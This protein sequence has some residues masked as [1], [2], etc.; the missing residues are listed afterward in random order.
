VREGF[1]LDLRLNLEGRR[2][3]FRRETDSAFIT[4]DRT[5]APALSAQGYRQ[6]DARRLIRAARAGPHGRI[7][8]LCGKVSSKSIGGGRAHQLERA[9]EVGLADAVG[10]DE[11]LQVRDRIRDLRQ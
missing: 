10:P 1:L 4:I 5:I 9:I 8:S 6:Y 7:Q 3:F 2:G 11:H